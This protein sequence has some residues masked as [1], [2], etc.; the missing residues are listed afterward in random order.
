M[1][2][3]SCAYVTRYAIKSLLGC[4]LSFIELLNSL[5]EKSIYKTEFSILP[6]IKNHYDFNDIKDIAIFPYN[7]ELTSLLNFPSLLKFNLIDI[8]EHKRFGKVGL[9]VRSEYNALNYILK[10]ID[11]CDWAK[12]DTLVIGHLTEM[13]KRIGVDLKLH[14]LKRCLKEH[15]NVICFDERLF[16][17][18]INIF[19]KEGL[20]LYC[21][22]V[23]I[24]Y[25]INFDKLLEKL[26]DFR[27]PIVGIFGTSKQQGKFT[28]QLA[29]KNKLLEL[30]YKVSQLGS[31]PQ[32]I[33]FGF[34]FTVPFGYESNNNLVSN[35]MISLC[36]YLVSELDKNESDII[37]VG[38][39]ANTLPISLS[40]LRYLDHHQTDFLVG[41]KPDCIVLNVNYHDNINY[42]ERTIKCIEMMADCK[43]VV[44]CIFPVGYE[45]EW[46]LL[47]DN[48]RNIDN[49]KLLEF[50]VVL[51]NRFNINAYILGDKD[52]DNYIVEQ[53]VDFFQEKNDEQ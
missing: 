39:Q 41:C 6:V 8:Y 43:V 47:M 37:I 42:I 36:N 38:S 34:D 1:L 31:E 12:F 53:I 17:E 21:P 22:S 29:I 23:S 27:T 24:A 20:L 13:E 51:K 30:G 35:D 45:T 5:K 2:V 49:I 46:D 25:N 9:N 16:D 48:K 19:T 11:K 44:L 33:L 18:Y 10:D 15:K 50:G 40:N 3:S 26:H 28:L 32:S 52:F 14:L 4:E 7:K